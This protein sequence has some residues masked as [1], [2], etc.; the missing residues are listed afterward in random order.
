M[1]DEQDDLRHQI[2]AGSLQHH[3]LR[4]LRDVAGKDAEGIWGMLLPQ[5]IRLI[6][7]DDLRDSYLKVMQ[8]SDLVV[9]TGNVYSLSINGYAMLNFLNLKSDNRNKLAIVK[10]ADLRTSGNYSGEE[11]KA[12]CDRKGAYDF[13]GLP[14]RI[15]NDLV[16]HPTAH[17]AE[18]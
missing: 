2:R 4:A 13:L 8:H 14:S 9:Q 18:S 5:K 11:L 3:I 15:G 6:S 1:L 10:K 16:P 7:L 12:T 17:L